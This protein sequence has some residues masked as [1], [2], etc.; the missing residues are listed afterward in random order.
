MVK[1]GK[2]NEIWFSINYKKLHNQKEA[3]L[4]WRDVAYPERLDK[5]FIDY[6]TEDSYVLDKN[7]SYLILYFIGDKGI[8]FTT[9]RT[10]NAE[11]R[12]KYIDCSIYTTFK[13]VIEGAEKW[14]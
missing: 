9:L 1:G 10:N 8:P 7:K 2:M 6:D 14:K 4:V 11:N 5:E 13:I 3:F 12:K